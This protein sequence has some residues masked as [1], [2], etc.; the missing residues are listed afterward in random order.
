[1]AR[2]AIEWDHA[3][4]AT[5]RR[6]DRSGLSIKRQARRLGLSERSIYSRRKQLQLGTDKSKKK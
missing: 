1:M 2:P 6:F 5:L 3:M 4:D